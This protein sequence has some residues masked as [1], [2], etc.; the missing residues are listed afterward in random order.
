MK[1]SHDLCFAKTWIWESNDFKSNINLSSK[2]CWRNFMECPSLFQQ[3]FVLCILKHKWKRFRTFLILQY[4]SELITRWLNETKRQSKK[5]RVPNW[6]VWLRVALTRDEDKLVAYLL[7]VLMHETV[8]GWACLH[9][10]SAHLVGILLLFSLMLIF[11]F[12]SS[13]VQ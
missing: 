3:N 1:S 7:A 11:S 9:S 12:P 4:S 6:A 5:V 13:L 8:E 10:L 2:Y